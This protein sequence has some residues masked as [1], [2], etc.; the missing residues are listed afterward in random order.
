MNAYPTPLHH[1]VVFTRHK[2]PHKHG[3]RHADHRKEETD[4]G[5]IVQL[6]R[7]RNSVV[8]PV[9]DRVRIIVAPGKQQNRSACVEYTD[10]SK[11]NN[12]GKRRPNHRD[13][14]MADFLPHIHAVH[15]RRIHDPR[16]DI[17]HRARKEHEISAQTEKYRINY[18]D[19]NKR[20][21]K[22]INM[23]LDEKAPKKEEVAP[24][25]LTAQKLF[26]KENV[27]IKAD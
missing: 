19:N 6:A 24:I 8:Y 17:I 3:D 1:R 18:Y 4:R 23:G 10:K 21:Q 12:G 7:K 16:I 2:P 22:W 15:A 20:K 9:C 14:H 11:Q 13:H 25:V 5:G 26:G 27:E